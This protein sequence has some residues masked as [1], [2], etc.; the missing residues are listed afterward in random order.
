MFLTG[1]M[2]LRKGVPAQQIDLGG[3][4]AAT[5]SSQMLLSS[6]ATRLNPALIGE[7]KLAFNFNFTDRNEKVAV[8]VSNQVMVS[9]LGQTNVAPQATLSGPRLLFLALLAQKVPLAA[10]EAKG[11]K[12]EG[13]RAALGALVS[14]LEAPKPAFNIAVP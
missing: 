6:L 1:A 9:E 8:S 13:D 7:R 3:D 5:L 12:V 2:E 14:S 11:L 4:G 10:L